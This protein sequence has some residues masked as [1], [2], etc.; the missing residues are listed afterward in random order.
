[1]TKICKEFQKIHDEFNE[2]IEEFQRIYNEVKEKGNVNLGDGKN[3]F[4]EIEVLKDEIMEKISEK[5]QL[6]FFYSSYSV[7][8]EIEQ[9]L[10]REGFDQLIEMEM[11]KD[12]TIVART[13]T[14]KEDFSV[15]NSLIEINL[16]NEISVIPI[17]DKKINRFCVGGN[18][19]FAVSD[20]DVD[21]KHSQNLYEINTRNDKVQV[22]KDLQGKKFVLNDDIFVKGDTFFAIVDLKSTRK[23]E[24]DQ[25]GILYKKLG[26]EAVFLSDEG[27]DF[28]E[29][30][31]DENTNILSG[32]AFDE[33]D[34]E[35]IFD[36][37]EDDRGEYYFDYR[38]IELRNE[39][40][41]RM[42]NNG[43]ILKEEFENDSDF[44]N[45]YVDKACNDK[46]N[47]KVLTVEN[48]SSVEVFKLK[49]GAFAIGKQY[50]IKNKFVSDVYFVK[51]DGKVEI[52]EEIE[53]RKLGEIE[54]LKIQA[55]GTLSGEEINGE[56]FMFDGEKYVF[57][58][59][60]F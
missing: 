47:K 24:E 41:N 42:L 59:T 36:I 48:T 33:N 23:G 30:G 15:E 5:R 29:I 53:G 35:K 10:L 1:M 12:G 26:E 57:L 44:V 39:T 27:V 49:G 2:K 31:L 55:D 8:K 25:S 13:D 51:E 17:E 50:F 16:D 9:D 45:F 11:L 32:I 40:Y 46:K 60:N 21:G 52:I 28:D 38:D 18:S 54:F 6:M 43:S 56:T 14:L 34:H 22:V 37:K 58:D 19:I 20:C 3:F 7:Y 4:K